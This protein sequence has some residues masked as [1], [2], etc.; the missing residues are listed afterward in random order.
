MTPVAIRRLAV[1]ASAALLPFAPMVDACAPAPDPIHVV[2]IGTPATG[3]GI[4]WHVDNVDAFHDE[5]LIATQLQCSNDTR[6]R[7]SA[8]VGVDANHLN[9]PALSCVKG[10]TVVLTGYD[11]RSS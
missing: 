11:T 4:Y 6:I 1:G 10:A 2:R 9:T 3:L 7:T 8:Y 5:P